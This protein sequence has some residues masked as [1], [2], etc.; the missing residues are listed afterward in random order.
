M[1]EWHALTTGGEV[2]KFDSC[3]ALLSALAERRAEFQPEPQEAMQLP[4]SEEGAA[5]VAAVAVPS[6]AVD[7]GNGKTV[8]IPPGCTNFQ[9][10]S[11]IVQVVVT[12][13]VV[14][15]RYPCNLFGPPFLVEWPTAAGV[16]T[17]R[18]VPAEWQTTVRSALT[19][20]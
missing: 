15:S 8:A 9:A 2:E 6:R 17:T 19:W 3:E 20:Y 7:V 14:L 12:S 1:A 16:A 10:G 4:D 13:L 5:D 11:N 18:A